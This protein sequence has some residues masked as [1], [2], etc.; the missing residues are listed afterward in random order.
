MQVVKNNGMVS[1][2]P[3]EYLRIQGCQEVPAATSMFSPA[4]N[5]W[6]KQK[7]RPTEIKKF[8]NETLDA[9][10]CDCVFSV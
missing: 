9:P 10:F 4:E 1:H 3:H 8:C 6:G 7:N 2:W 5:L